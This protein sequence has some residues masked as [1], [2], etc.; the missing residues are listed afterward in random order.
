MTAN[1]IKTK[2]EN[3]ALTLNNTSCLIIYCVNAFSKYF[4]EDEIFEII[5]NVDKKKPEN[6]YKSFFKLG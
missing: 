5:N 3:K 2:I 1:Y 6:K 4:S